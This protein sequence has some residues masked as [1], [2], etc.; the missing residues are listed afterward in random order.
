[1]DAKLA[2]GAG[3]AIH[4]LLDTWS[5][6]NA[7]SNDFAPINLGQLKALAK[8][9]YDRLVAAGVVDTY[10]WLTALN[11]PDDFTVA[12]V[13]QVKSLFS[14]AI[15]PPNPLDDSI[16]TRIA[17]SPYAGNLALESNAIWIWNDQQANA[18]DLEMSI[19]RRMSGLPSI[20]SVTAGERH[21]A[22][23]AEDGTVWAWGDNANG[24]LGDGTT[25]SR[26]VP[27]T[28][29][30]LTDVISVKAG[31]AHMLALLED[32]TVVAWGD[33][34]YGQL[35]AGDQTPSL[36]PQAIHLL[37]AVHKIAAG[38]QSS[39]ALKE[40]GTVWTWGYQRYDN[41]QNLFTATPTSVPKFDGVIDVAAGYEHVVAVRSDGTVWAWGSNYANQIGNG[42]PWWQYQDVPFHVPNLP[43]I[44]KVASAY[45]H[46]LAVA[47]N[48]TVWA[49]G[50]NSNGQLGDGTT[51]ARQT[52]VQVVGLT[53]VISIATAYSFS[54]AMK[55]DGTVWAWGGGA[56]GILP[57]IDHH[58][59]QQV[60]LGLYDT[61]HNG[62]DDRWEMHFFENLDQPADADFDKDGISN[63]QEYLRGTDPADYFNGTAP[64]IEIAGGNNQIGDPG[65]FLSKPFKVRVRDQSGQILANAPIRF[66]I[67]DGS[68][69]LALAMSGQQEQTLVVRTDTAGEAAAYHS[70]PFAA[71]TSTRVVA[72][73]G[74]PGAS[75]STTFRGV[76]RFSLPPTPTPSATPT[77]DPNASPTPAP[78]PTTTPLAPYRYAIIDLGKDMYPARINNTGQILVRGLDANGN[79]GN[80]RWKGGTLQPL[81]YPDPNFDVVATDIN[82][83][84]TV[85]GWFRRPTWTDNAENETHA[86]LKW[87]PD[88]L[89]GTKVS[90]PVV[91]PS[92]DFRH[93]GTVREASFSAINNRND[94]YGGVRDG[95]VVGFLFRPIA[96][97]NAYVWPAGGIPGALSN[98]SAINDPSQTFVSYWQGTT[99]TISRANS[100]GHYIGRKFTPFPTCAGFLE[101]IEAGMIDGQSVSF[102]PID[103]NETGI[104]VGSAGADMV[105]SSSP[106]S[107][108]TISGASPLAIN[109]HT[110][111]APSSAAS[112][113][114]P[115]V[116]APQ[117]LAWLGNA[118]VLWEREEG[119]G[120]W[121]PF[122]LEEMIPSMDGWEYL[123]PYD[124]NDAGAIVGRAWYTDP[125]SPGA[126]GE[127]HGFLLVPVELMV[128]GNRDNEMSFTDLAAHEADQTSEEKPYRF[129]VNDDNDGILDGK[130]LEGGSADYADTFLKSV[131][132]L[133]DFTR[134]WIS[135][136][137][138][139]E[140]VKTGDVTAQLQWKPADGGTSWS[141]NAG[142]P[143]INVFKAVEGDGG[144]RYLSDEATA[145]NQVS[146]GNMPTEYSISLGRVGRGQPLSLPSSL[147]STLSDSRPNAFLLFEAAG[148]GTGELILTFWR[149]GTKIGES[150]GVWLDLKNVRTM[151]ERGKITVEAPGIPDPWDNPH[152]GPLEWTWDPWQWPPDIDTASDDAIVFVHG[153]RLTYAEYLKWADTTFKRLYR[154]G[155]KGRFY[156]FHWPT[157]NG[158][159][160]GIDPAD[161]FVPGGATY[162]PSEYRAWQS[163]P[164]LANF[165]NSLP[166]S[167]KYIIGHSMGN[168]VAGSALRANMQVARYAMC[169]A[170]VA[171]MAY[172]QNIVD[173]NYET[174]DTDS[175]QRTRSTFGLA[176]KFNPSGTKLINFSLPA[177]F[178][179]GQWNANNEFF[180]PQPRL[181]ANYYY[182]PLNSSG[183]KLTYEG[184]VTVRVVTSV[185][186][187]MGYVTQSRSTAEGTKQSLSGSINAVVNMGSG[188][189]G[190]GTEHSAAWEFTMQRT[191]PF[192]REILHQFD[193]SVPTQS[194]P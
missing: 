140:M 22:V 184:L 14:F 158:E 76:V 152:P 10:P 80:F 58:V 99:D 56:T 166:S 69:G 106:D 41:G 129:W 141:G 5:A 73:A 86:G 84:G 125:S 63:R 39:V 90:A 81:T 64:L 190:F 191:Y 47:T 100:D 185:A 7:T 116:P 25:A 111:P 124:M 9:F 78:N 137:G 96:V 3:N 174:P 40:D 181:T 173:F 115:P 177:D 21:L 44:S 128:D 163:G 161:L 89:S 32:G 26:M 87:L 171:A 156:A 123:E 59:P 18:D 127:Q 60:G 131:R 130:E 151:Y 31:A 135:F 8:P 147:F 176:N 33:N 94:I 51:E 79:W 108:T 1:M 114:L 164:A 178:A 19:P 110:R 23:L 172:D 83:S 192:W 36:A 180:K 136:K 126:P 119:A 35:G 29:P 38:Y 102:D 74:K 46:T 42:N 139:S 189:F 165:V 34:S 97:T 88:T 101:G 20:K 142:N 30:N 121:H 159:N 2:G 150:S 27:L 61:N 103:I 66:T 167:R 157:F 194:S 45:D 37:A 168:A 122:G 113:V 146:Y 72:S 48:G 117:I 132:D 70:L 109:D 67:S 28:I 11:N 155:Y 144:N 104:V 12:N 162:N 57:G 62:M 17:A 149:G 107:Q 138:I 50:Y 169:N 193:F 55:S 182:R 118:V 98:A 49:W 187:A 92:R 71:G 77:P 93:P 183:R 75:A 65:T 4:T 154:V 179:L 160:N 68:G 186:E 24:Q 188:G 43:P 15:P 170:A 53:D 85:V 134:L 95:G 120:T 105:V 6:T 112:P 148:E 13:G 145:K 16:G 175:D 82:D 91:V 143:A 153:W 52:P 133:E 54:I